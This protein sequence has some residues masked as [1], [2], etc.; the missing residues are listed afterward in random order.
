MAFKSVFKPR[1]YFKYATCKAEDVLVNGLRYKGRIPDGFNAHQHLFEGAKFDVVLNK[2]GQLDML[3]NRVKV[4]AICRVVFGGKLTLE[5]KYGT[6][7]TNQFVVEVDDEE[8]AVK[9]AV[10]NL[11]DHVDLAAESMAQK[12]VDDSLCFTDDLGTEPIPSSDVCA[13][14]DDLI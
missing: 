2:A 10:D 14:F 4:G 5:T 7:E 3:L 1:K 6:K 13:L 11:E 8:P 9:K 12:E